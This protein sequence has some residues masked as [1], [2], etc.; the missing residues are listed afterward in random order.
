[1]PVW[2][3]LGGAILL[4]VI[5]TTA[6]QQSAQFS[7]LLPTAI[8]A[9]CYGLSFY[10]LSVVVQQMPMGVVYAIWSG[11]GIALISLIGAVFLGQRLDTAAVAGIA[12]IA[13]GVVVINMFSGA[14]PH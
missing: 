11:T 6:L 8:M 10:A 2:V 12:L 13:A 14:G 4:E 7:R 3:W 1:M 5:G 9:I